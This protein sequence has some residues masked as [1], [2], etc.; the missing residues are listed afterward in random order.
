MLA[1]AAPRVAE[2]SEKRSLRFGTVFGGVDIIRDAWADHTHVF[3][4]DPLVVPGRPDVQTFPD[5]RRIKA[6]DMQPYR[7]LNALVVTPPRRSYR[8]KHRLANM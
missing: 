4:V 7:G 8:D 5:F 2:A 6:R 3:A 1:D